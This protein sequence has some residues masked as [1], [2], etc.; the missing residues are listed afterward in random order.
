MLYVL[1]LLVLAHHI[2]TCFL[3]L[4]FS[5]EKYWVPPKDF[6]YLIFDYMETATIEYSFFENY[7]MMIYYATF[8]F[9]MV[10]VAP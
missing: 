10:D 3:W 7:L 8:V 2:I 9:N 5:Y 6:G 1:Y 4:L